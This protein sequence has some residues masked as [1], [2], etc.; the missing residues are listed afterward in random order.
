MKL[1][2]RVRDMDKAFSS[3]QKD[4]QGVYSTGGAPV[5]PE[6]PAQRVR[7][8]IVKDPDGFASNSCWLRRRQNDRA[9]R[10]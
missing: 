5:Q 7:A 1:V 3:V 6:G 8:V 9:G 4:I 10:Q 2:L